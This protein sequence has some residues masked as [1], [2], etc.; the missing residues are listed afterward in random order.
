MH[1]GA[2]VRPR[3]EEARVVWG[4]GETRDDATLAAP[5]LLGRARLPQLAL[6]AWPAQVED[7]HGAVKAAE[8][9]AAAQVERRRVRAGHLVEV[10]V[11]RVAG[12]QLARV[13][14]PQ[15][16]RMVAA[17]RDEAAR[18][19]LR[20]VHRRVP[21]IVIDGVALAG[22]DDATQLRGWQ[23]RLGS[24]VGLDWLVVSRKLEQ[25]QHL[26]FTCCEQ[27]GAIGR[28]LDALEAIVG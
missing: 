12:T 10:V 17:R 26:I 13:R 2:A 16:E 19:W 1:R 22:S 7:A 28:P 5:A 15:V 21:I 3:R 9:L 11:R 27:A 4:E 8:D 20:G 23:C 14:V 18:E 6:A 25:A 24:S